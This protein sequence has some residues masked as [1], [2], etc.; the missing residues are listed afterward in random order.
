MEERKTSVLNELSEIIHYIRFNNLVSDEK[1]DEL[2]KIAREKAKEKNKKDEREIKR[3][4]GEFES[5]VIHRT[6]H[7]K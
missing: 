2:R 6:K 1:L 5:T 7:C 4:Y 3:V